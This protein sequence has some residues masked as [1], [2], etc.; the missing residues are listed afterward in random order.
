M[1]KHPARRKTSQQ[2]VPKR[3]R[4]LR[5]TF[6]CLIA[7]I[8]V[9]ASGLSLWTVS[10]RKAE[11][12]LKRLSLAELQAAVASQPG[13]ARVLYYL[14]RSQSAAGQSREA[15]ETLRR[16]AGLAPDD[17][18]TFTAFA[19]AAGNAEGPAS[20]KAI[21][22]SFLRNHA[23]SAATHAALAGALMKLDDPMGSYMEA[24]K[25][26]RLASDNSDAWGIIGAVEMRR[27][28]E[29]E[30]A[31]AF[32]KVVKARPSNWE[33]R[34]DL[35]DAYYRLG[36]VAQAA[37]QYNEANR[38]APNEP[39][40]KVA[41]GKALRSCAVTDAQ[42]EESRRVL[43]DAL[44][45]DTASPQDRFEAYYQLGRT[46]TAQRRWKE[47][48]GWLQ[49]AAPL[50]SDNQDVHYELARAYGMIGDT[51][52]AQSERQLH[53]AA[54]AYH[55]A[56]VKLTGI[57]K[58]DPKDDQALLD[59]GR[60]YAGHRYYSRAMEIYRVLITRSPQLQDAR[61]EYEELARQ[62]A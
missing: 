33:A 14:G 28:N 22:G 18:A 21:L 59:L 49:L 56:E 9:L 54:V 32:A 17:D 29:V 1:R 27:Q 34:V 36:Q 58:V 7:T 57:L 6:L 2:S 45:S 52:S 4:S 40:A 60:L 15:L 42:F 12:S 61:R 44:S 46:C 41:L 26:V 43:N 37:A 38:L 39:R 13:N 55:A 62:S 16:A 25:A 24:R 20:A 51:A 5:T 10:S 3:G 8:A 30:A 19:E 47:A 31:A 48:V 53:E 50:N 35:G 23:N 11:D